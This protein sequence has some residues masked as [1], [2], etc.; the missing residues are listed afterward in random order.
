M[1]SSLRRRLEEEPMNRTGRRRQLAVPAAVACGGVI[2]AVARS[3][4]SA[5]W[6]TG[7][8]QFPW[9]TLFVNVSGSALLGCALRLLA[10]RF[11]RDRLLRPMLCTGLIGAYTTFSTFAVQAV[12]LAR[13]GDA[14][15]GV[16]YVL[17]S[18]AAGIAAVVLGLTA[19][20]AVMR[21]ERF[22]VRRG[23]LGND[24]SEEGT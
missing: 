9:T 23:A 12:L 14:T 24:S 1:R 2:G 19:A 17:G 20:G 21:T 5:T 18:V 15:T 10:E 22:L 16:L 3:Y 8:G 11:P 4:L 7:S 13:A 6:P